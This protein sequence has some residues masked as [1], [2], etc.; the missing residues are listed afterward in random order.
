M[1]TRHSPTAVAPAPESWSLR[2]G[3]DSYPANLGDLDHLVEAGAAP[4]SEGAPR[5]LRG[6][7]SRS[8][9]SGL[10]ERSAVT[11]VGARRATPYG[12][13]VAEDLGSA[14]AA[15]GLVVVSGM[16][17]GIDSAAHRGALDAGGPTI[18]VLAGGADVPYPPSA[19]GLHRTILERGGAVVSEHEPGTKPA[20]WGFPARNRIMAALGAMTVVVEARVRS[21]SRITADKALALGRAVGAVPGPTGSPLSE[22]PHELVKQGAELITG[23]QDVLDLVLGVGAATAT[24]VGP[25]LDGAPEAVLG[26]VGPE[27]TSAES[28]AAAS[29]L[30][31]AEVAVALARLELM[32][33]LRAGLSGYVRTGLSPP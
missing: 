13:R 6:L 1:S 10:G 5:L 17:F 24:R 11:I 19:R 12:R 31:A 15:A 8:L 2:A 30:P 25:R 21:G 4:A 3:R 9:V 27:G 22:G 16:A 18:A 32:G 14:L 28:V 23:A 26:L 33:Y 29:A 20:R 7:G